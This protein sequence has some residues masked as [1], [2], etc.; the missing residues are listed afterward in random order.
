MLSANHGRL[1]HNQASSVRELHSRAFEFENHTRDVNANAD[2]NPNA[3]PKQSQ[4]QRLRLPNPTTTMASIIARRAFSTSARRFADAAGEQAL[5][6]ESKRNP[7]LIVRNPARQSGDQ[8][9]TRL[10][11]VSI[12]PGAHSS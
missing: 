4:H 3:T 8:S 12:W 5:K 7:E 6:Q 9:A 10:L 11:R 1:R 2:H